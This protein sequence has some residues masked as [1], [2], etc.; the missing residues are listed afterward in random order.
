MCVFEKESKRGGGRK[1]GREEGRE[2]WMIKGRKGG[3]GERKRERERKGNRE[4]ERE[5]EGEG[6]G[7]RE[8]VIQTERERDT[9]REKDLSHVGGLYSLRRHRPRCDR[10]CSRRN[11]A[12]C[13][14][15]SAPSPIVI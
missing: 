4:R 6:E 9:E 3:R 1:G 2:G 7:E 15:C 11:L 8:R 10:P 5:R 14:S 12:R 13:R